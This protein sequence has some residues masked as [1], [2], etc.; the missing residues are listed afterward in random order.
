MC[1][2]RIALKVLSSPGCNE[3]FT[4]NIQR[5]SFKAPLNA[6]ME[7]L[8]KRGQSEC[9]I[10]LIYYSVHLLI[11][12][13]VPQLKN[14]DLKRPQKQENVCTFYAVMLAPSVMEGYFEDTKSYEYHNLGLNT[15]FGKWG[16]GGA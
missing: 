13:V 7:K 11:L 1:D 3:I 2:R 5:K 9:V 10:E 6:T 8:H 12:L 15:L 16:G 14:F 4:Q